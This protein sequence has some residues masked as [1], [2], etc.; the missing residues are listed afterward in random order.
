MS[1][2]PAPAEFHDVVQRLPLRI[3]YLPGFRAPVVGLR[4]AAERLEPA[5][6]ERLDQP[7]GAAHPFDRGEEIG[8]RVEDAPAVVSQDE[9]VTRATWVEDQFVLAGRIADD[10]ALDGP[11]LGQDFAAR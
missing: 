2:C 6:R 9:Q 7:A 5:F 4:A 8:A 10:H 11:R 3:R 1:L